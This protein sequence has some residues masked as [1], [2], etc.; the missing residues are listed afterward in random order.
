MSHQRT[1]LSPFKTNLKYKSFICKINC[2]LIYPI[3]R[4]KTDKTKAF[5][6]RKIKSYC[7]SFI[8]R[9]MFYE[10]STKFTV[11]FKLSIFINYWVHEFSCIICFSTS[12]SKSHLI[13]QSFRTSFAVFPLNSW[14]AILQPIDKRS[15]NEYIFQINILNNELINTFNIEIIGGN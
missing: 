3:Y 7:N 2:Y 13:F 6:V 4:Q 5:I 1:F 8:S 15:K 11:D 9:F 12:G 10:K 14:A